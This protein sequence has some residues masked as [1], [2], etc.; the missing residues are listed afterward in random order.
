MCWSHDGSVRRVR[1]DV[2]GSSLLRVEI[3]IIHLR[4]GLSKGE[5]E[6]LGAAIQRGTPEAELTFLQALT[7]VTA[8]LP[9]DDPLNAITQLDESLDRALQATGLSAVF[10]VSGRILRAGPSRRDEADR[11]R[12]RRHRSDGRAFHVQVE[13]RYLPGTLPEDDREALRAALRGDLPEVALWVRPDAHNVVVVNASLRANN[14][15]EAVA[16][17]SRSLDDALADTGLFEVFDVTGR[18]LRVT[19][20]EQRGSHD[21]T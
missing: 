18:E 19:P 10:D 11:R 12:M 6:A 9:G 1:R 4:G 3:V 15:L 7:L 20:L 2:S 8:L 13:V 14:A 5:R 17:L 16:D 21:G